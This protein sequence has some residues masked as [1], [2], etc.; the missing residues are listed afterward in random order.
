MLAPA[1]PEAALPTA[2]SLEA[3]AALA[4]AALIAAAVALLVGSITR[5]L[6][7]SI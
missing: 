2:F 3:V 1:R 4:L 5:R 7:L 6:L